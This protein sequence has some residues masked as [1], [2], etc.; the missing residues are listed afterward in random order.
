MLEAAAAH[1]WIDREQASA[2]TLASIHQAGADIILTYWAIE[3][4]CWRA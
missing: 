1:G 4:T 2:E 3:A